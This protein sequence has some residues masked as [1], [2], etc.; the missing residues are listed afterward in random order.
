M[1]KRELT[2]RYLFFIAG[3]FVNAFGISLIIK[4]NLGSSPISSLPYTLSLNFPV[5]LGQFTLLLN[6]ALIAG[7]IWLLK[8]DF[9]KEQF[10][11]IPVAI[12][13][14]FFIDCSMALLGGFT[15]AGYASQI[16]SLITGCAI[17]GLGVSMEVI[18]NVVMLSGE[19]FVKA[20]TLRTGKE[21]GITKIG[22]D[23]TLALLA[24][25]A[26]LM[27]AGSIEGVREGTII[28]ALIVGLFA[29]FFNRRLGF[30]NKMIT[31]APNKTPEGSKVTMAEKHP[32]V[33]ITFCEGHELV[34]M[35]RQVAC[36]YSMK[37]RSVIC[38]G[39][40]R[41]IEDMDEKRETLDIIMQQYTSDEFKY[42]EPAVRNVKVWEVKIDKMTCRSFGLRPSEVTSE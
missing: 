22:F 20:I 7:Q 13:F 8:R 42:S 14:S 27:I 11:Q 39:N 25:A 24:C 19:A 23:T 33:C 1:A 9:R 18:A 15:P 5:T 30:V 34:Y 41:F 4:A 38:H 35:H 21:F 6:A 28:A 12:L 3:L 16:L 31:F 2:A 26:S 36:S 17:L 29:R 37:S 40:V 10:L 32:H